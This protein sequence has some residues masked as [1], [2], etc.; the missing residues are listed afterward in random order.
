MIAYTTLRHIEAH[1]EDELARVQ[2]YFMVMHTNI[3]RISHSYPYGNSAALE[4]LSL[5]WN[6]MLLFY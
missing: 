6:Q 2:Y 3:L 1:P 5:Y 4:Y